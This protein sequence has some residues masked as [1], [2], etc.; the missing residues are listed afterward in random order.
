MYE[1][2]G[3]ELEMIPTSSGTAATRAGSAPS[4]RCGSGLPVS[5]MSAQPSC[6]ASRNRASSHGTVSRS[7]SSGA[8]VNADSRTCPSSYS[9]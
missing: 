2:A 6:S 9:T 4:N 7:A 8:Y 5:R 1:K 3:L